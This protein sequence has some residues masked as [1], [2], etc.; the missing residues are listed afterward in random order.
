MFLKRILVPV[1]FSRRSVAALR[2]AVDLARSCHAS[3]ELLHVVPAPSLVGVVADLALD[4]PVALIPPEVLAEAEDQMHALVACVD[5]RG[6]SIAQRIEGGDP[7]AVIVRVA[8][9]EAHDL[10]A[11][12]THGRI[13]LAALLLGSV[14]KKLITMA[15]CP[16]VTLR[17]SATAAA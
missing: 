2:Y 8:T 9:E 14:A 3:L 10:I 15:P 7:A 16:V 1:D 6:V 11:L 13:G 12:G 4:R 5:P 17:Q